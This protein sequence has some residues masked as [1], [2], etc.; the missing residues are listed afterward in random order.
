MGLPAQKLDTGQTESRC[1][2]KGTAGVPGVGQA[3]GLIL[4]P[5]EQMTGSTDSE[6]G[7]DEE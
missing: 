7:A 4:P 1:Q 5:A 3:E 6:E 2:G